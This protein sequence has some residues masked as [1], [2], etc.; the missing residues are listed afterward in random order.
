MRRSGKY[1]ERFR[2]IFAEEGVP[3]DLV[4]MAHVESGFKTSAYSRAHAKGIFQFISGT[5]RNYGLR[6][7]YWADERSDPEK[8]ARAAA[9]YMKRLYDEFEDWNLSVAAYNAGEGKV[10]SAIRRSGSRDFWKLAKTRY[11]RRETKN[12]VPAVLAATLIYKDPERYG[13]HVEPDP[14]LEYDSIVVNGAADFKVLARCA[15]TDAE[16]IRGLN[17]GLRR[18]QT[19]PDGQMVVHVPLGSGQQTRVALEGVPASE[20]VLYARYPIKRG[21]TLSTIA[22]KHGVSVGAIQATNGMGRRT[23]IRENRVLLI[24]TSAASRYTD[25]PPRQIFHGPLPESL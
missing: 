5:A 8:S 15:G 6:V 19:P 25:S 18:N 12:H 17:P 11:L 4:H 24:P 16:T 9:Q 10:R 1:M 3:K 23:L 7:D 21:D 13:I 20:R 22:R 14:P 2:E